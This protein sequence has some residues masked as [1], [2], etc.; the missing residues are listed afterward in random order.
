MTWSQENKI[1]NNQIIEYEEANTYDDVVGKWK[2]E[3]G[4]SY[5]E[6]EE[7]GSVYFSS[8]EDDS[9]DQLYGGSIG[10]IEGNII[11]F[12]K[13]YD[14]RFSASEYMNY[15]TDVIPKTYKY[16]KDVPEEEMEEYTSVDEVNFVNNEIIKL[17]S[18]ENR[19][20]ISIYIKVN[21]N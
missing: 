12:T 1:L 21:S 2:S 10:K 6:I 19:E 3:S 14:Y 17:N 5:L 9:S 20:N 18:I 8:Y 15:M 16:I 4:L 13:Y 7:D 11:K